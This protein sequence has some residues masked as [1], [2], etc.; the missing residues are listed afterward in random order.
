MWEPPPNATEH[1]GEPLAADRDFF[2]APPAEIGAIRTAHRS[3][4][5]GARE[6]PIAARVAFPVAGGAAAFLL[7]LGFDRL[8]AILFVIANLTG[9]PPVLFK[10]ASAVSTR[11]VRRL[12]NGIYQGTNFYSHR[13]SADPESAVFHVTGSHYAD[14]K[15]PPASNFFARAV[16]AARY[17]YVTPTVD[18][19]FTRKGYVRFY[20]GNRRWSA[21]G[22]GYIDFVDESGQVSRCAAEDIGSA[23]L[24]GGDLTIRRKDARCS[25]FQPFNHEGVFGFPHAAMHNARLFLDLFEKSPGIRVQ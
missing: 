11:L 4:K 25:L 10:D 3:L 8:T 23:R 19:E 24:F 20:M 17:G 15:I 13:H 2:A 21:P 5:K 7:A 12:Q 14:A 6:W 9:T 18:A 22:R 1:N 16:E